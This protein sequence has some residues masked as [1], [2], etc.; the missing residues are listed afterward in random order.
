MPKETL[1]GRWHLWLLA[2][3]SCG[4]PLPPRMLQTA[5]APPAIPSRLQLK[6]DE[7][8]DKEPRTACPLLIRTSRLFYFSLANTSSDVYPCLTVK[9]SGWQEHTLSKLGLL[10][11]RKE[12]SA[13]SRTASEA[14]IQSL[15]CESFLLSQYGPSPLGA[16]RWYSAAARE[17]H[18][19]V[20]SVQVLVLLLR[21]TLGR[22]R[23]WLKQR[24]PCHPCGRSGLLISAWPCFS[25]CRY[26]ANK[27][28]NA[29]YLS[30]SALI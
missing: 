22:S 12:W 27:S 2:P 17:A 15:S 24:G 28:E 7:T 4:H 19:S 21:Q 11:G 18:F 13:P 14:N 6:G 16:G 23:W 9:Q 10:S 8:Q 25:C 5:S 20:P 26:L 30:L 3:P 1:T 29:R